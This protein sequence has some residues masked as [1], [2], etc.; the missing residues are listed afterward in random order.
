MHS[1]HNKLLFPPHVLYYIDPIFK[2]KF[3]G[4]YS[5]IKSSKPRKLFVVKYINLLCTHTA[6]RHITAHPAR[7]L[8]VTLKC[9]PFFS[10]SAS[11]WP[12]P[13]FVIMFDSILLMFKILNVNSCL[14]AHIQ[15][16]FDLI[17]FFIFFNTAGAP[18]TAFG[19][20]PCTLG[21]QSWCARSMKSPRDA[22]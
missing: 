2:R 10:S 4:I 20:D 9:G 21:P 1:I 6:H 3:H 13:L 15:R 5:I 8:E 16:Q 18:R 14:G 22:M 19:G 12:S 7:W 11:S 17:H